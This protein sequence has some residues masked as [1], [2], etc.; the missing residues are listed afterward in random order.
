MPKIFIIKILFLLFSFFFFVNIFP[1]GHLSAVR[2]QFLLCVSPSALKLSFNS[3]FHWDW[4]FPPLPKPKFCSWQRTVWIE[5]N[6]HPHNSRSYLGLWISFLGFLCSV[7]FV[8]KCFHFPMRRIFCRTLELWRKML[9][10]FT[11]SGLYVW[12]A[13]NLRQNARISN[14]HAGLRTG[15]SQKLMKPDWL[16]C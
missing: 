16:E 4:T 10:Q 5:V 13:K 14:S 1:A 8:P 11:F 9:S 2:P 6:G 12:E 3:Q 15:T 7:N